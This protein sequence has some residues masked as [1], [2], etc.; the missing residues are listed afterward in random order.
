M[1]EHRKWLAPMKRF[2]GQRT[3]GKSESKR[4]ED[5]SVSCCLVWRANVDSTPTGANLS[6]LQSNASNRK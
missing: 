3:P 5:G 6:F 4:K 1:I 2:V